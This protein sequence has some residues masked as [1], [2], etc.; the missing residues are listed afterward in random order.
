MCP[1]AINFVHPQKESDTTEQLSTHTCAHLYTHTHTPPYWKWHIY[2]IYIC[3]GLRGLFFPVSNL[4]HT[5]EHYLC[6]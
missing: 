5:N 3:N 4:T 6:Q 1:S 2:T